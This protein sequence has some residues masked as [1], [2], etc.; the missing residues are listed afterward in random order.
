MI[1]RKCEN[2]CR[3]AEGV[4]GGGYYRCI[5]I[6][7]SN[8]PSPACEQTYVCMYVRLIALRS[9]IVQGVLLYGKNSNN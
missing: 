2:A 5:A 9:L 1:Y 3:Q 8:V 7:D 6:T 4:N